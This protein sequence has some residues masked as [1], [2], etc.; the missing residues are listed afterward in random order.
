MLLAIILKKKQY[1]LVLKLPLIETEFPSTEKALYGNNFHI[2]EQN[3]C[4]PP[5]GLGLKSLFQA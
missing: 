4:C 3:T 5:Q 1:I 2:G